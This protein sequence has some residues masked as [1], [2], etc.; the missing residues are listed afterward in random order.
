MVKMFT[1]NKKY[2]K[3]AISPFKSRKILGHLKRIKHNCYAKYKFSLNVHTGIHNHDQ[4][5]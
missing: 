3:P 2:L 1:M 4:R 5:T